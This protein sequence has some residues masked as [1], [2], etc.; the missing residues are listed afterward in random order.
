MISLYNL[1]QNREF[2]YLKL[3]LVNNKKTD[4]DPVEFANYT[5]TMITTRFLFLETWGNPIKKR[6]KT[7]K[8]F[9]IIF[10]KK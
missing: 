10:Y 5:D 6:V 9:Y 1:E 3:K 7:L 8:G 4:R 2:F